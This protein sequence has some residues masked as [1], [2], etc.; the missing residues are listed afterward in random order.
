MKAFS[1][2]TR[3]IF[4]VIC[5]APILIFSSLVAA[6]IT[7]FTIDDIDKGNAYGYSI[8]ESYQSALGKVKVG[9]SVTYRTFFRDR[10]RFLGIL[11]D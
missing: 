4:G 5:A 9:T 1:S 3:K 6:Y 2:K 8:D 11:H 7:L 10:P